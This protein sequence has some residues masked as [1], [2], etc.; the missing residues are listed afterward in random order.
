MH[1]KIER[2]CRK[3]ESQ[4]TL[5]RC[6]KKGSRTLEVKYRRYLEKKRLGEYI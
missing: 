3:P 6:E 1:R 2:A 4:F 5:D